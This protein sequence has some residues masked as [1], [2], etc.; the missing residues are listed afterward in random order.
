MKQFGRVAFL[1]DSSI[2]INSYI[3]GQHQTTGERIHRIVPMQLDSGAGHCTLLKSYVK[4]MVVPNIE[5]K[6]GHGFDGIP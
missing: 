5:E 4:N 6:E 1:P 3:T 2:Y